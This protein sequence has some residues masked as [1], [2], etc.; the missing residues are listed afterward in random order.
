MPHGSNSV[1]EALTNY[2][3]RDVANGTLDSDPMIEGM[4]LEYGGCTG[5]RERVLNRT[6]SL[7][8]K[9]LGAVWVDD[10]IGAL[11]KALSNKNVLNNTV[12]RPNFLSS[13]FI[14]HEPIFSHFI[15]F[16]VN[17]LC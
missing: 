9:E 12:R 6:A 15:R 4:T 2:S 16:L 11:F 5:Y 1:L 10:S 17:T 14:V 13:I 3:C 7:D 8:D